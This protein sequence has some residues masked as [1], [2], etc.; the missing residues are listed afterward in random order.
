MEYFFKKIKLFL[1]KKYLYLFILLSTS[2]QGLT[3][4]SFGAR[5]A[6]AS[7]LRIYGV[8]MAAYPFDWMVSN[9]DSL[10][11]ALQD[12]FAHFLEAK[13][14]VFYPEKNAVLDYYKFEFL[15]DF[16]SYQNQ[17][18]IADV[19]NHHVLGG[20]IRDDWKDFILVVQ[21]KY[22]RRIE[23]LRAVFE[24]NDKV[25]IIRHLGMN[26][27]QSEKLRD[28]LIKKYPNLDF[29]L[30]VGSNN[31]NMKIDWGLSHVK[32]YYINPSKLDYH[33]WAK[34]FNDLGI[35][36]IIPTKS[37]QEIY[38]AHSLFDSIMVGDVD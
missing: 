28:L 10:Y 29:T 3:V 36:P 14:L 16:P 1:Q 9:F 2:I 35:K 27:D 4:I 23:R 25:Y 22:F 19:D 24:G 37:L 12:D 21:E 17:V 13:Y 26:K 38:A 6:P 33:E 32:N 31:E 11:Q 7:N 15:H 5:C 34:I 8:R 20:K 18:L 30:I